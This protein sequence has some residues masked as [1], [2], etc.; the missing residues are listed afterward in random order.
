MSPRKREILEIAARLFARK[1]YRG[2]SIRDIGDHSGVLGG[3]LYHHIKSKDALFIELHNAALDMAAE[4]IDTAVAKESTPWSRLEAACIALLE[5]QADADSL[6][7]PLMP[8]SR[9]SASSVCGGRRSRIRDTR[10]C[11]TGDMPGSCRAADAVAAG[12]EEGHCQRLFAL[13]P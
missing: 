10:S 9:C 12:R 4:R 3:S 8:N 13:V 11:A 7:F 2:T 1:G 6:T 5:I